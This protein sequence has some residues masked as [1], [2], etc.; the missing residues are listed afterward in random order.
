MTV[1][2]QLQAAM[3][4]LRHLRKVVAEKDEKITYLGA[5]VTSQDTVI[6]KLDATVKDLENQLTWLRRKV[7][8]K[9]CEKK[10]SLDPA[11][12][13]LF[14]QYQLMSEAEKAKLAKDV[15]EAD[16]EI[17]K[18]IMVKVKPS[19]KPLDITKLPVEVE[20]IYPEGTTDEKD[21][22]LSTQ[23]SGYDRATSTNLAQL[24]RYL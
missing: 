24:G 21:A 16:K 9:M 4:E 13:S 19:R 5:K 20:N 7:F 3:Q 22:L 1:E 8:G 23:W 12:L 10:L 15:E 6:T 17:T 11:Q 2:E 18:T 14:D